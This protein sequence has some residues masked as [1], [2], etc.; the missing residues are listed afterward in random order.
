MKIILTGMLI[1]LF[2]FFMKKLFNIKKTI[3]SLSDDRIDIKPLLGLIIV[4]ALMAIPVI[5]GFG[6]DFIKTVKKTLEPIQNMG[7]EKVSVYFEII[8]GLVVMFLIYLSIAIILTIVA[9]WIVKK[10]LVLF[11]KHISLYKL[12]NISIYTFLINFF[13]TTIF[14]SLIALSIIIPVI[15]D[16]MITD[17]Q[18]ETIVFLPIILIN[19]FTMGLYIYGIMLSIKNKNKLISNSPK[20]N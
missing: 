4:M 16:T 5:F 2:L 18:E 7:L 9:N 19:L 6:G 11:K 13:F 14:I 10:V 12:I 17:S 3:V 1:N 15:K 8:T 20:V